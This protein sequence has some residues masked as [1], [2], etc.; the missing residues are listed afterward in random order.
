[1][2]AFN[3]LL[4]LSC[5]KTNIDKKFDKK[6][7]EKMDK[8]NLERAQFKFKEEQENDG[9][10]RLKKYADALRSIIPRQ[11][12][13]PVEVVTFFRNVERLFIY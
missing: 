7:Q 9:P 1:V 6:M 8:I 13:E 3:S 10:A 12:N 4:S 11:T 2:G 5:D